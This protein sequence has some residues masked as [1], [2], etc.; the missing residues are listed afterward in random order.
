MHYMICIFENICVHLCYIC[1]AGKDF[2]SLVNQVFE[3]LHLNEVI[4]VAISHLIINYKEINL[5]EILKTV[6]V[7]IFVGLVLT[8]LVTMLMPIV[9]PACTAGE[10]CQQV[11]TLNA[12]ILE[13]Y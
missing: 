3:F 6:V 13:L 10:F 4:V 5:M 11:S 9:G 1:F 7:H 2:G 12:I 8:N